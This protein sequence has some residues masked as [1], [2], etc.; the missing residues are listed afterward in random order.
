[1]VDLDGNTTLSGHDR[2][3]LLRPGVGGVILFA[4]N[5][6]SPAQLA[7]LTA[8]IRALREPRL[9][10]AVDQ[11]G[12]RV[13]RFRDGFT[14]LPSAATFGRMYDEDPARGTAMATQAG[15]VMA[16][17]LKSA[18]VDMSFAPVLDVGQVASE[19]IG[20]RAFHHDPAA[21]TML[22]RAFIDGMHQAGMAATGKHFP[23]HG[24][25]ADDSHH[26]LPRDPRPL[27]RLEACDLL[28]YQRLKDHLAGVMTAHVCFDQ[29]DEQTPTF[30]SFWLQ[31]VLRE[32][33]GFRGMVFSDD[34][35]MV[36]A[37]TCGTPAERA[38]LARAAGCDM[39]VVCND[40][41]AAGEILAAD[42]EPVSRQ[43]LL[44][45]MHG[46][47]GMLI[48]EQDLLAAQEQVGAAVA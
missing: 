9:L 3:Q 14:P 6:E 24:G 45:T 47:Q 32:R 20:D 30:S 40:Q 4:R 25:V 37:A 18:G 7:E 28:P 16:M 34:L 26:C 22:A 35:V 10:I 43:D 48:D 46:H 38:R 36:A 12:G 29:V 1:M 8:Q 39:L 23:G 42:P 44:S 21:V 19:V 27:T 11:E 41:S 2:A 15:L 31:Q 13:Q 5:Y 17:E 33:I